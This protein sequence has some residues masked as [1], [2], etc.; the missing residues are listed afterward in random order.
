MSDIAA[1]IKIVQ[2]RIQAAEKK[3]ARTAETITLLAVSKK[4]SVE[5]NKTGRSHGFACFW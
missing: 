2:Q 5:K 4:Q 1:N 3:F